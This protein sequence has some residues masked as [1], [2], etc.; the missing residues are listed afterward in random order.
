MEDGGREWQRLKERGKM[1][2]YGSG[3]VSNGPVIY[4]SEQ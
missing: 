2:G 3:K 4:L 1:K